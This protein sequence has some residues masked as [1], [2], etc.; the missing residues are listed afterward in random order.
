MSNWIDVTLDVL[1]SS[2]EEINKIDAA[3]QQPCQELLAWVAKRSGEDPREIAA[4]VKDLVS[5]EPKRNLG[6][7]HPSVN[8]ARRF[9]NSFKDRS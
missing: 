6:Y 5:F 7:V 8:K 9:E 1:A 4:G 2:P 3:L